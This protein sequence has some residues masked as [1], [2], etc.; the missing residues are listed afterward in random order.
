MGQWILEDV[1][2]CRKIIRKILFYNQIQLKQLSKMLNKYEN[3][4]ARLL[5]DKGKSDI[6]IGVAR[7]ICNVIGYDF[8]IEDL[9]E[10]EEF[11]L[12]YR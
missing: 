6:S 1:M 7:E 10:G 2:S 4:S 11:S 3:Y 8:K 12:I 9:T 5:N